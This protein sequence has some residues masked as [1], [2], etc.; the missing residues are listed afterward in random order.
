MQ[1]IS[2][3]SDSPKLQ[4]EITSDLTGIYISFI[5]FYFLLPIHYLYLLVKF[6]Y[7]GDNTCIYHIWA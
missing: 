3:M 5:T 4:K 7:F 2:A 1:Q 6:K